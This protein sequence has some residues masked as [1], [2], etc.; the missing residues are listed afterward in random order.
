MDYAIKQRRN[1]AYD[2]AAVLLDTHLEMSMAARKR[3]KSK[4]IQIVGSTPCIEGLLLK[5]LDEPVPDTCAECKTRMDR[6]RLGPLT[7][8]NS[9]Q[10]KFPKDVLEG[11]QHAVAEL[12]ELLG[13]FSFDD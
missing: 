7:M 5:I 3:A 1:A 11:R 8:Q 13:L 10:V 4:K 12:R 2:R 9:Y 6:L